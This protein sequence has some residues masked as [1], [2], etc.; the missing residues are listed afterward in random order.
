MPALGG[1]HLRPQFCRAMASFVGGF[2]WRNASFVAN[3]SH[4]FLMY[5]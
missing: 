5:W 1:G 4:I 2:F 3:F